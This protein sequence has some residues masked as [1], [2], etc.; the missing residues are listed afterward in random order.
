MTDHLI[1]VSDE[2]NA[3]CDGHDQRRCQRRRIVVILETRHGVLKNTG[4]R[5]F[6]G[7]VNRSSQVA[8]VG[9]D[10]SVGFGLKA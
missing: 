8:S 1:D 2:H 3:E 10:M 9:C 4:D 5:C 6:G 7:V